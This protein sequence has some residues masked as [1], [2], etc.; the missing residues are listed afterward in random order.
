[1]CETPE[2][3]MSITR[4]SRKLHKCCECGIEI[5]KGEQ[6]QYS[7]GIWDSEPDSYKQCLNC[8]RI[9]LGAISF[10]SER[11]G[12]GVAFGEVREWFLAFMCRDF[13][14][15]EFL[16]E[17]SKDVGVDPES[18]NLLLKIDLNAVN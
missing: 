14:G 6:Y 10:D 8:Y 7:S 2:A 1:M 18:L 11:C 17:M 13:Q 4:K 16:E 9:M 12:D 3:F 15:H 5:N